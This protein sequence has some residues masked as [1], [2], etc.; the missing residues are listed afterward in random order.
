M[1]LR[2]LYAVQDAIPASPQSFELFGYDILIDA[3][4][5]PWLIEVNSSPSL[6]RANP[7][8]H[9]VK[10]PLVADTLA[11]VDPPHFDRAVWREMVGWRAAERAGERMPHRGAPPS[12]AAELCA[13]LHGCPPS[14]PAPAPNAT[15][16]GAGAPPAERPLGMYERIAPSPAWDRLNSRRAGE[17]RGGNGGA[18]RGRAAG[19]AKRGAAGDRAAPS[20]E[21][22]ATQ[23]PATMVP[24]APAMRMSLRGE[25]GSLAAKY[26]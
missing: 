11:L 13:L 10:E 23:Q 26:L 24:L 20:R 1:I 5:K 15:E 2:S 21:P 4:L 22:K 8:D 7:L 19:K 25:R 12:L 14:A 9:A 17:A 16:P 6:E 3:D 18:S